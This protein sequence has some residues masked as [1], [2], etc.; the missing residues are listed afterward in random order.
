MKALRTRD[1][2]AVDGAFSSSQG[3]YGLA[4]GTTPLTRL[5]VA[6]TLQGF[7]DPM[8]NNRP[9]IYPSNT[10]IAYS[11]TD[12]GYFESAQYRFNSNGDELISMPRREYAQ[13][14]LHNNGSLTMTPAPFAEDGRVQ[15]EN[16]CTPQTAILAQFNEFELWNEWSVTID[17]NHEAY[18]LQAVNYNGKL[19]RCVEL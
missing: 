6:S 18:M 1:E 7:A 2:I 16:P 10:G 17:V 19:P 14:Q 8:N 3:V 4:Q 9:F 13:Y 5:L 12:D 11:F 15:T